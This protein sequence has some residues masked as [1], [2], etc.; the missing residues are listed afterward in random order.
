MDF[1]SSGSAGNQLSVLCVGNVLVS[2]GVEVSTGP[3]GQGV[4]QAVGVQVRAEPVRRRAV[5]LDDL[6]AVRRRLFAGGRER[7]GGDG[8]TALAFTEDVGKHFVEYN[9]NVLYVHEG[10]EDQQGI[11]DAVTAAQQTHD[12]PTQTCVKTKI[13][14]GSTKQ[15]SHKVQGAPLGD[16]CLADYKRTMGLQDADGFSVDQQVYARYKATFGQRG[17]EA[18]A[19]WNKARQAFA[20]KK[21]ELAKTLQRMLNGQLP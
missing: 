12:K 19:A 2:P 15:G 11:L 17:R 6:Y 13:G 20:A 3:L 5:Q 16:E 18:E 21:P 14:F 1:W 7:G 10:N 9:L 4:T 8:S